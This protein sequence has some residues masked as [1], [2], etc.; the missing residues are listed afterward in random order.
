MKQEEKNHSMEEIVELLG[1]FINE[2]EKVFIGKRFIVE[3]AVTTL[4]AKGH[5]L[6]ED[7]PGVGKTTLGKA[8][9]KALDLDFSRI[10]FTSDMLPS[11]IIGTFIFNPAEAEFSFRS[12]PIFSNI[13]MA[14][15][16]NRSSPRTQ[17]ALLEAMNE[18]QVTVDKETFLLPSPFFVLATQNPKEIQ[19]TY[20]LPESQLDRF[21]LSL[22]IGYPDSSIEKTIIGGDNH[23]TSLDKIKTVL[24]R[25]QLESIQKSVGEVA[26]DGKLTSYIHS[27]VKATRDHDDFHLGVSTRAGIQ[28]MGAA[29]SYALLK[30]RNYLTP[31][32]V[33]TI[34]P[35]VL[36][37][38][39]SLRE[40]S[41]LL[42]DRNQVLSKID[43]ILNSIPSP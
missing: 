31:D 18:N 17:S 32:D 10:Q 7:I 30:G 14:D 25:H 34:A 6:I 19:G 9:A 12:G 2:I 21:L 13:I 15:E 29:R 39:L 22:S 27:I 11:D 33:Q 23:L 35:F 28:M 37:H 20:A 8:L 40:S 43:D 41:G 26:T 1:N 24:N 16:L 38:R 4:M 3:L 36:V 42:N 5:L